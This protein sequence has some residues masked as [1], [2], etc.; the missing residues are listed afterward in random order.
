MTLSSFNWKIK[1]I[2]IQIQSEQSRA[3]QSRAEQSRA[4]QSRAEPSRV[5]Q[6]KQDQFCCLFS[7]SKY[8]WPQIDWYLNEKILP[9]SKKMVSCEMNTPFE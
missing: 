4:E 1:N 2:Q 9:P 3:E 6:Q 7:Q 8:L 5:D